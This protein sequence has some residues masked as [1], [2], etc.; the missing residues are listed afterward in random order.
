MTCYVKTNWILILIL[1]A[2]G[3]LAAA[4]FGKISLA[5]AEVS[6]VYAQTQTMLSLAVSVM[7]VIGVIFGAVVGILV[8]RQGARRAVLFALGLGALMSLLQSAL[9]PLPIFFVSRL[10]EGVSHLVL[11]VAIPTLMIQISAPRHYSIV[12]GLWGM[13]F[14]VGFAATAY[15]LPG[16]YGVGGVPAIFA[17]HAAGMAT[18]ALVLWP[19]LP[20]AAREDI[21]LNWIAL[22]LSLYGNPRVIAPAFGFFWHTLMFVAL[23]TFLPDLI[24]DM[25]WVATALPLIALCGTFSVGFLTRYIRPDQIAVISFV[26]TAVLMG[27]SGG[28]LWII[29]PAFF[30]IGLLPG[31][32]FASIPYYNHTQT[33]VARAN[34]AMAQLG[35][36]GTST[37]TPIYALVIADFGFPGLTVLTTVLCVAGILCLVIIRKKIVRMG[38]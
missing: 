21:P 10:I 15:V 12:M 3:L 33:D 17:V 16:I 38:E 25:P 32:S 2:A 19:L 18:L 5:L 22:H 31:A 34:G 11:V 37:G 20:R 1:W 35:N 8:A 13:F 4:Q 36:L 26:G 27:I 29:L 23:L 6:V 28:S 7:G 9:P 30:V 24:S 14:G